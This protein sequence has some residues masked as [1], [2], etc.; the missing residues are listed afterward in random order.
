VKRCFFLLLFRNHVSENARLG[1]TDARLDNGAARG[2][3]RSID[4]VFV[5]VRLEFVHA[6]P[7][8][9]DADGERQH[10]LEQRR[11]DRLQRNPARRVVARTRAVRIAIARILRK[12]P[13]FVVDQLETSNE[14]QNDADKNQQNADALAAALV[15]AKNIVAHSSGGSRRFNQWRARH[16]KNQLVLIYTAGAEKLR[17]KLSDFQLETTIV[18]LRRRNTAS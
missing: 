7:H 18:A 17:R 2:A 5:A 15:F 9:Q 3:D 8:E 4:S 1:K 14:Q 13:V 10:R 12:D 6:E 11:L 16:F